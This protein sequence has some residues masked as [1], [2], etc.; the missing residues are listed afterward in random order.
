MPTPWISLPPEPPVVQER[1]TTQVDQELVVTANRTNI[2]FNPRVM[3]FEGE[4]VATYGLS[5]ITT[6]R[7]VLYL[8]PTKQRGLAEGTT[9]LTD[10]EGQVE[11]KRIEFQ[12][13][14]DARS[15]KASFV[16]VSIAGI[17]L[18]ADAAELQ[19]EKW[20]FTGV[21]AQPCAE[22][23]TLTFRMR[24]L[25][26]EPGKQAISRGVT[27]RAGG[28]SIATLPRYVV[29]LDRRTEGLQWPQLGYRNGSGVG[30]TWK[31]G[32]D[33]GSETFFDGSF[34][35][36]PGRRASGDATF[37]KSFVD[38]ERS[39]A[40]VTPRSELS[41]SYGNA[42]MSSIKVKTPEQEREFVRA[43][44]LSVSVGSS[45]NQGRFGTAGGQFNKPWEVILEASDDV[46]GWGVYG[47]ARFQRV[48][49]AGGA[50]QER[51]VLLGVI[52]A[53]PTRLS[54]TTTL[55]LRADLRGMANEERDYGWIRGSATVSTL[56]SEAARLSFGYGEAVDSG[57]AAYSFDLPD[58]K[59][60]Y[61][62]RVDLA[63]GPTKFGALLRWNADDRR[64]FGREIFVSQVAGCFEPFVVWQERTNRW[65]FG[66]TYRP[67]KEL[68]RL[69]DRTLRRT[70]G[71]RAPEKG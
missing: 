11:A 58:A 55:D 64:T 42:F 41:E 25:E 17:V 45:W 71:N 22:N 47:Q 53:P 12:W 54:R 44:R 18:Q 9:K 1:Q 37:T 31:S 63:F 70:K 24:S 51:P 50:Y 14:L 8:D 60:V 33:L 28:K 65:S 30:V 40:I 13:K 29:S 32:I 21:L 69:K 20:R 49:T 39:R 36:F 34:S 35:S 4:V 5:T 7:L 61:S 67:A 62:G 38:P 23:D 68:D 3:I 26:V 10:P 6:D 2:K 19:G 56:L 52:S 59:R 43:P 16:K 27:L 48:G 46:R 15:A 66:F 57:L